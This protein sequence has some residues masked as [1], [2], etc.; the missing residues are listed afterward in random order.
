VLILDSEIF[1][2]NRKMEVYRCNGKLGTKCTD[3][4]LDAEV[5]RELV[6][7]ASHQSTPPPSPAFS[8]MVF[9]ALCVNGRNVRYKDIQQRMGA[10]SVYL[11]DA[12]VCGTLPFTQVECKQYYPVSQ[13]SAVLDLIPT[14]N[15]NTDGLVSLQVFLII[16][17]HFFFLI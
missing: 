17:L 14:L 11:I 15:H 5:V 3:T 16:F 13:I 8:L 1:L 7:P 6:A 10:A 4:L 12:R 9:D 2:I